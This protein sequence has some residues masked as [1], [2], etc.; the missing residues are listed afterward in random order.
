MR[1][2][3]MH[4]GSGNTGGYGI[5]QNHG[6]ES[7]GRARGGREAEV[8]SN[9]I[10]CE[11]TSTNCSGIDGGI[12]SGAG[13][14]YN[15]ATT[16]INASIGPY[17]SVQAL[18]TYLS[19]TQPFTP[20]A[21]GLSPWDINDSASVSSSSTVTGHSAGT[22]TDTAQTWTAHQF[23]PTASGTAYMFL[24][25][26]GLASNQT[27][28]FITDNTA[29]QLS[30]GSLGG[31]TVSNG[32]TYYITG[33]ALLY[34]GANTSVSNPDPNSVGGTFYD[35]MTD[36]GAGFASLLP[37]GAPYSVCDANRGWCSE[38]SS[39]TSTSI[40]V[41]QCGNPP[42]GCTP[43]GF[44]NGDTY[45]VTRSTVALDQS[46]RGQQTSTVLS[47]DAPT[48]VAAA[49]ETID[50]VYH[51]GDTLSGA[52]ASYDVFSGTLRLIAYRDWYTQATGIQTTSSSPFSCNGSTGGTGWGT[53]AN[54]PSSCSGACSANSPGCGYWATDTNTLYTWQSGAWVNLLS[55]LHLS[56]ST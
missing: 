46:A 55:A 7:G 6:T 5:F 24:D 21:G 22:I 26:T 2:N 14:F 30:V 47:G 17:I 37:S 43:Y 33:T 23:K 11:G 53:L 10:L 51:W 49:V 13:I 18:R 54:R 38:I 20:Q 8:Y 42:N 36:S 28:A 45:F 41:A 29:T 40:S 32:D 25:F 35:T 4:Q 27:I 16:S 52:T 50:P 1:Y 56:A 9:T 34:T 3:T 12:R 31:G 19:S 44:A 39:F 48:P 15:N